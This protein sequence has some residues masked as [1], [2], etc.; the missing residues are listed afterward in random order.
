MFAQ[1]PFALYVEPEDHCGK[2]H[3]GERLERKAPRLPEAY[4]RDFEVRAEPEAEVVSERA[5]GVERQC[6]GDELNYIFNAVLRQ[7]AVVA[8]ALQVCGIASELE[9]QILAGV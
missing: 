2:E 6:E 9:E 8:D 5:D 3:G 4:A 7:R 1:A